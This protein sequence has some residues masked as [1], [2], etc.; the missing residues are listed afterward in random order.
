VRQGKGARGGGLG[1][2]SRGEG[3]PRRGKEAR[4]AQGG[5]LAGEG[6]RDAGVGGRAREPR[7]ARGA[8]AEA[9]ARLGRGAR[10][11]RARDARVQGK[12]KGR[13]GRER[14]GKGRGGEKLTPGIQTP[15][16]STPNPRAPQGEKEVEEGGYCAGEIK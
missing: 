16:I 10:V 12:K 3:G 7:V 9:V 13:G 2:G 11:S 14:E 5:A 1:G 15:A 4:R 8:W 6:A